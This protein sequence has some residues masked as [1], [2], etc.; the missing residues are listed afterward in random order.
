MQ[1]ATHDLLRCV[2][3]I[4]LKAWKGKEKV[5]NHGY[6][7]FF[8]LSTNVL[9]LQAKELPVVSLMGPCF[10]VPGTN[11]NSLLIFHT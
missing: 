5:V 4:N 3:Q 6:F 2:P 10:F 1:L 11:V 7:S 9:F 8:Y